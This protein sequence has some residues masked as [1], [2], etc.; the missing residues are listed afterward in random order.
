MNDSR[1]NLV[2][3]KSI[4]MTCKSL[5]ENM[6]LCFWY[7]GHVGLALRARPDPGFFCWPKGLVHDEIEPSKHNT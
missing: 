4:L 5:L 1:S 2:S 3:A 7:Q 6:W